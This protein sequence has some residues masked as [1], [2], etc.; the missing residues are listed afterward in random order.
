MIKMISFSN[1]DNFD[2][3]IN[4]IK[5]GESDSLAQDFTAI[6]GGF[7]PNTHNS[8]SHSFCDENSEG[9]GFFDSDGGDRAISKFSFEPAPYANGFSSEIKAELFPKKNIVEFNAGTGNT[10]EISITEQD[11]NSENNQ[12]LQSNMKSGSDLHGGLPS[13]FEPEKRLQPRFGE[14]VREFSTVSGTN[15]TRQQGLS[16]FIDRENI[17]DIPAIDENGFEIAKTDSI[18]NNGQIPAE[19][20]EI[21]SFEDST[22]KTALNPEI[23]NPGQE[24]AAVKIDSAANKNAEQ[25]DA[26]T[27]K[28][29]SDLRSSL[30]ELFSVENSAPEITEKSFETTEF[31]ERQIK[32]ETEDAS[33]QNGDLSR[34]FEIVEIRSDEFSDLDLKYPENQSEIPETLLEIPD[35][36]NDFLK[37]DHSTKPELTNETA[38]SA[39]FAPVN[40][41]TENERS[42][43]AAETD[44]TKIE[45][46]T[47][48]E[49]TD[50]EMLDQLFSDS[51]IRVINDPLRRT[52][53][54]SDKLPDV[55]PADNGL[56]VVKNRRHT[57]ETSGIPQEKLDENRLQ[58]LSDK[59][60]RR[61][62]DHTNQTVIRV[63]DQNESSDSSQTG[64]SLTRL[65]SK[66]SGIFRDDVP[67]PQNPVKTVSGNVHI[68][69]DQNLW[70][71]FPVKSD[72]KPFDSKKS[73]SSSIGS[74]F[75]GAAMEQTAKNTSST[76]FWSGIAKNIDEK[77]FAPNLSGPADRKIKLEGQTNPIPTIDNA[78]RNDDDLPLQP[79][80]EFRKPVETAGSETG[81]VSANLRT[82]VSAGSIESFERPIPMPETPIDAPDEFA[83]L[84]FD[85]FL[86]PTGIQREIVE[87]SS[88]SLVEDQRVIDQIE[89]KIIELAALAA[90]KDEKQLL[91][92]RLNPAE[93][94]EVEVRI[95]RDAAG[96]IHTHFRTT[97]EAA[98]HILSESLGQLRE[99][100]QNSGWQVENLEVSSSPYSSDGNE[101]RDDRSRQ[102]EDAENM[103]R[104]ASDFSGISENEG[105]PR[106]NAAQRLVNLRA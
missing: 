98:R 15:E 85:R 70:S 96:K 25:A 72:V 81:D 13:D 32:P 87:V 48:S 49:M 69:N 50:A 54:N 91:R 63:S 105:E 3:A 88:D 33:V 89:P 38:K 12:F 65:Y 31:N 60:K 16:F 37:F 41:N 40:S 102:F 82:T 27:G 8:E 75:S 47:D 44:P 78:S 7:A 92:M 14:S 5:D 94:G 10:D 76:D 29:L 104:S 11:A 74:D 45:N 77:A 23:S 42:F 6:L 57:S 59:S 86:K 46:L 101:S 30:S 18:A 62:V 2:A 83:A 97:N 58:V 34:D 28:Q 56:F 39:Q 100:L 53:T 9:K 80:L 36:A 67:E 20:V 24:N 35:A 66:I 1:F 4:G 68:S 17:L 79:F 103:R 93:L 19:S 84:N 26:Q 51:P 99:S 73:N 64:N 52:I 71:G 61:I 21:L 106:E 55:N 43:A 90:R 22:Q 95:E